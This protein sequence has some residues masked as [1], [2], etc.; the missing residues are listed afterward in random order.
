[1]L[2][3]TQKGAGDVFGV[4]QNTVSVIIKNMQTQIIDIQNAYY[5]DKKTIEQIK[6]FYHVDEIT[7]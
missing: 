2:G 4:E 1:M 6:D 5:K 7:A 3:R